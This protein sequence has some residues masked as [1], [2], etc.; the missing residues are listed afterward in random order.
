VERV[1]G[2]YVDVSVLLSPGQSPAT[3]EPTAKQMVKL[4]RSRAYFRIGVPFEEQVVGKLAATIKDPQMVDLREGI[5]LRPEDVHCSHTHEGATTPNSDHHH[6][7]AEHDPH[8]WMNPR[9]VKILAETICAALCRL[10]PEHRDDY[11]ANRDSFSAELD[12][13][14]AEISAALTPLRGKEF[15]VFHPAFGYFAD[16]YGL[17]QVAIEAGGRQPTAKLLTALIE[18]AKGAG[19]RLIIVQPQFD[20]R[21]AETVAKHIGGAVVPLDPLTEDYVA[22]LLHVASTLKKVL[23]GASSAGV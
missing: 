20:T 12:R 23:A 3:Y 10:D 14:D 11:E 17:K 5:E 13:V 19:V 7:H 8:V 1:G 18:R 9:L 2:K 6:H 21:N 16:A 22:N 4:A 15:Y